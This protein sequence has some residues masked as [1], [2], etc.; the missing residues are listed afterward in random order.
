MEDPCDDE[1]D[2][3]KHQDATKRRTVNCDPFC[4]LSRTHWS[5]SWFHWESK[6]EK[7]FFAHSSTFPFSLWELYKI[8]CIFFLVQ[9]FEV[10]LSSRLPIIWSLRTR[11]CTWHHI[12]FL[13]PIIFPLKIAIEK[14]F[15]VVIFWIIVCFQRVIESNKVLISFNCSSPFIKLSF[16]EVLIQLFISWFAWALTWALPFIRDFIKYV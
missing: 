8:E 9:H 3:R 4:Y 12:L 7:F 16:S 5:W 14:R 6:E 11:S 13:N 1:D 10:H 2:C 15:R